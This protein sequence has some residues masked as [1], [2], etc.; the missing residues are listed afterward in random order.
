MRN[1]TL[2]AT[3]PWEEAPPGSPCRQ[4]CR[5][6]RLAGAALDSTAA[7]NMLD[8][9]AIMNHPEP[10]QAS[11]GAGESPSASAAVPSAWGETPRAAKSKCG[12]RES[13]EVP[14]R[15]VAGAPRATYRLQFNEGFR[16]ADALAL[17][18]YLHALGIS[19]L[20]ASPLLNAQPMPPVEQMEP[21]DAITRQ[22]ARV[23]TAINGQFSTTSPWESPKREIPSKLTPAHF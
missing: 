21:R 9:S 2:T 13:A 23:P 15:T 10:G 7:W 8:A 20:Y 5:P 17:V 19:H 1:R 3:Q 11:Q 12:D 18:P 6:P 14:G 16:L 22:Y 4:P